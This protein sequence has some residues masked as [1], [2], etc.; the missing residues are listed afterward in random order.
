MKAIIPTVRNDQAYIITTKQLLFF[1]INHFLFMKMSRVRTVRH[2]DTLGMPVSIAATH[3]LAREH[4]LLSE[5]S[6]NA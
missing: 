3:I 5:Y 1:A 6:T 4:D 2:P